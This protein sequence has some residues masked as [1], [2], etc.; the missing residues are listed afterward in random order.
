MSITPLTYEET[1][2]E[3]QAFIGTK[4]VV[5]VSHADVEFVVATILGPLRRA[6]EIDVG[7]NVPEV[8]GNFAGE[9]MLFDLGD[10][11][12][13]ELLG[14]FAIW[15][16]GFELGRRVATPEGVRSPC[17]LQGCRFASWPRRSY[18]PNRLASAA[19]TPASEV[20]TGVGT[21]RAFRTFATRL[22]RSTMRF[23]LNHAVQN[24]RTWD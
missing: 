17:R 16:G 13:P 11:D 1:L 23:P 2:A 12:S 19:R 22:T 18:R 20:G 7:A 8:E 14:T 5:F 21:A 10:A 6:S 15:R 9:S 24:G 4:V 3:L